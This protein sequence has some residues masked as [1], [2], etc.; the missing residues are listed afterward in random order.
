MSRYQVN[1][2]G[3]SYE[4]TLLERGIDA[5]KFS[6][7]GKSYSV[8]ISSL[9]DRA[10]YQTGPAAGTAYVQPTASKPQLGSTSVKANEILAPMPGVVVAIKV[11]VGDNV[12]PGQ[13][14]AV[15]EAMKMENNIQAH[16][17]G[18]VKEI[19]VKPTQE[20]SGGQVLVRLN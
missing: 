16:A 13:T 10:Q 12:T 4:V 19:L 3:N 9:I 20:V 11:A 2:S 14:V 6:V 1:V 15:I 5:V 18:K 17:A 8:S 7:N